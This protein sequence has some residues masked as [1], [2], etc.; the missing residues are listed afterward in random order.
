MLA[1]KETS[2]TAMIAVA[3]PGGHLNP[4][5]IK[6]RREG[7]SFVVI[8]GFHRLAVNSVLAPSGFRDCDLTA[9]FRRR[10]FPHR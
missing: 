2:F 10:G 3:Q 1:D 5:L 7:E 6:N 9:W 8:D 4:F